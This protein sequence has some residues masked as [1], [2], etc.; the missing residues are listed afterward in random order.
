MNEQ[1]DGFN[2]KQNHPK[3][4]T[5][6][7]LKYLDLRNKF[8]GSEKNITNLINELNLNENYAFYC[9]DG[10]PKTKAGEKIEELV[11]S[12]QVK[13]LKLLLDNIS[14][15]QQAYGVAGIKMLQKNKISIPLNILKIVTYIDKRNSD[16]VTCEGCFDGLVRHNQ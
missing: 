8:Y 4:D 11:K 16:I 15:E 7:V 5:T 13:K 9:G 3:I 1:A 2:R 6:E 10:N 14:C 12:K